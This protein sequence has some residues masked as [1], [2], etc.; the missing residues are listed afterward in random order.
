ETFVPRHVDETY[1]EPFPEVQVSEAEVDRN[2]APLL[3][4]EPVWINS[5][6]RAHQGGFAVI[7]VP[8]GA[9]DNVF[10]SFPIMLDAG[11]LRNRLLCPRGKNE[12]IRLVTLWSRASPERAVGLSPL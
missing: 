6:Q 12:R 1:A 7:D 4:L 5:S 10:H 8:S 3:F 11:A 2:A 9:Y